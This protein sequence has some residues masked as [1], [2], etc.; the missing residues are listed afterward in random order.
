M[1]LA[2]I[3][4]AFVELTG[5]RG[6]VTDA[7]AG[8]YTDL[9]GVLTNGTYFI[10]AGMRWL[11]RRWPG[12]G[13]ERRYRANLLTGAYTL[14]VPYI[15]F[16]RRLDVSDGTTITHP[17]MIS[18]DEM[19]EKYT[20]P[21]S[22][23]DSGLPVFWTWNP[24]PHVSLSGGI[25]NGSFA[26]GIAGWTVTQGSATVSGGNL[27]LIDPAS[28]DVGVVLQRLASI[29][30][31]TTEITVSVTTLPAGN[32]FF[33]FGM[34]NDATGA[35]DL[36]HLETITATG[37]HTFD[38]DG[39]GNWDTIALYYAA[40]SGTGTAVIASVSLEDTN[41]ESAIASYSRQLLFMPPADADYGIEIWGAF[42]NAP[43]SA[44]TSYNWWTDQHPDL[45]IDAARAVYERQ[46][47]RNVS[48]AKV[49]EE[50]CERE[51]A[52]L[53]SEYRH[54]LVMGMNPEDYALN[55]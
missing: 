37:D 20:E 36:V 3:R 49:F 19:R 26:D 50:S 32:L 33:A 46:G 54:S 6:L 43:L 10:N 27:S 31:D 23:V 17:R 38:A 12:A 29:Y 5:Y 11:D 4:Q 30:P 25:I 40:N 9:A 2:Q 55:G 47:H 15:Q 13:N 51:I 45:V 44:E 28:G 18:Y 22:T 8:T 41:L 14:D 52:R 35:Y 39:G 42:G 48:G 53:W 34:W 7:E 24:R 21:F 1:T 16:V